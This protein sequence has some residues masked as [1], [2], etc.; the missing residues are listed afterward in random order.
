MPLQD[1]L[2]RAS[3][4]LEQELGRS[5][6]SAPWLTSHP[7]P[8]SANLG[9]RETLG[10]ALELLQ[11]VFAELG[12]RE[13]SRGPSDASTGHVPLISCA[14][15]VE[16]G[17]EAFATIR[18]ANEDTRPVEA[19]LYLSNFIAD[20]GYEIPSLA[21]HISPRIAEIAPG[22]EATFEVRLSVPRQTP[23][24]TYSGLVQVTNSK[25]IKAVLVLE[26]L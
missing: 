16:A 26:V 22:A 24:G 10:Q 14:S 2:S 12:A 20:T 19:A 11:S 6:L 25:Y 15:R 17:S 9:P 18:V 8:A 1:L 21:G 23:A 3:S 5:P 7:T 4:L 13:L